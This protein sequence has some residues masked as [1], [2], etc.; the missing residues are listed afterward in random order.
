[1]SNRSLRTI[2][3]A[4]AAAAAM[5]VPG[6][7][8]GQDHASGGASPQPGPK[9]A[10]VSKKTGKAIA[11][12]NAPTAVKRL[13][14]AANKI[15][16]KHYKWGGGHGSW[17]DDGYDCSGSVSYALHGAGLLDSP[18]DS[19]GLMSWGRAGTGKWITVYANSN[20]TFLIVAG[21]RLD[22]GWRDHYTETHWPPGAP[23]DGPRWG[24]PDASTNGYVAR[25]PG[26]LG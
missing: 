25:H 6:V 4:V 7:A 18:E 10:Y 24:K 2:L 1:M 19:T 17:N 8:Y 9:Y 13:I 21:L 26:G 20:H 5:L 3:L 11:P 22:T 15:I 23:S 12:Y 16:K 14:K